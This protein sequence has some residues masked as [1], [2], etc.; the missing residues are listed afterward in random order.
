MEQPAYSQKA[1]DILDAA[2]RHMRSG[3]FDAVSF[4]DLATEVGIKSASVH[5]HFPQKSDLGE[6]VVH[7]YTQ[8]VLAALGAPDDPSESVRNRIERLCAVYRSA[9]LDDG[10]VC[11]CC[12]LGAE[13]LKL[14]DQVAD[15]V[16]IY[17]TRLLDWTTQ[18]LVVTSEGGSR[19]DRPDAAQIVAG[20]QGAMILA[21][22]TKRPA[23]FTGTA[24]R[25][26]EQV[27]D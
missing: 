1:I 14:P 2:E 11:L 9:V 25:I 26:I 10:L 24:S 16:S 19:T 18:A 4:R 20:L 15:A 3:G 17:F 23:L 27:T 7:R 5:Y 8:H 13:A 22:A 12:V 21:L 6:A